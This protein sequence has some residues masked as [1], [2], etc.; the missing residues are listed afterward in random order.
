MS[1]SVDVNVLLYASDRSSPFAE[2]AAELLATCAAGDDLFY[3]AW[4]TIMSYLRIATHRAI[5]AAPLSPDE[6]AQNVSALLALPHVRT[7]GEEEGFWDVYRAV[8]AGRPVRGNAVPDAHV[9]ALLRQH[10]VVRLY[11]NDADFSRFDFLTVINPFTPLAP[12]PHR[13]R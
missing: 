4:P 7:L 11:T 3:L 12:S 9:A 13:T 5:F 8:T 6:A 1:F 10:G 2:Q